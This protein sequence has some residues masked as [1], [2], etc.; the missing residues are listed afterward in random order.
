MQF[1]IR[2]QRCVVKGVHVVSLSQL[3]KGGEVWKSV[4]VYGLHE[5]HLGCLKKR[6]LG[7][8]IFR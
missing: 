4:P 8:R 1:I 3:F 5:K 2:L 6:S 7:E